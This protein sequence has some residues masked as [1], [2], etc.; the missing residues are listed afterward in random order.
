MIATVYWGSNRTER[1]RRDPLRR[2]EL[3]LL[4]GGYLAASKVSFHSWLE[5][6]GFVYAQKPYL[7][8]TTMSHERVGQ[9]CGSVEEN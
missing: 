8:S 2:I 6:R 1:R 7:I 9:E 4:T 5:E 3:V